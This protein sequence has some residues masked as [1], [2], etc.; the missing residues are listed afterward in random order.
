MRWPTDQT[1][2]S[3]PSPPPGSAPST[4]SGTL[5]TPA[6]AGRHLCV[7]RCVTVK[8]LTLHISDTSFFPRTLFPKSAP[9]N[10]LVDHILICTMCSKAKSRGVLVTLYHLQRVFLPRVKD[11][12]SLDEECG[13]LNK[14]FISKRETVS[15]EQ[16][17]NWHKATHRK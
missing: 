12:R 15:H 3:T 1:A 13:Y 16:V 10:Q 8:C 5:R 2:S 17:L 4:T 14:R 6:T 9:P 7:C 11:A